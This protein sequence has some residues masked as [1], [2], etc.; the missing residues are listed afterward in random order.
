MGD[1]HSLSRTVSAVIE[2]VGYP[3]DGL[4][5]APLVDLGPTVHYEAYQTGSN[6][7]GVYN[8]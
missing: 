5:V 1:S 7:T 3:A 6:P 8:R 4:N 2:D